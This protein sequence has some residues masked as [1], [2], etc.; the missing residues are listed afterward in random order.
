MVSA[1]NFE[2]KFPSKF[3][4]LNATKVASSSFYNL[5]VTDNCVAG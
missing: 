2:G 5:F 3:I 1:L 4:V